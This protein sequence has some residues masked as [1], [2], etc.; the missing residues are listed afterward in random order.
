MNRSSSIAI[1]RGFAITLGKSVAPRSEKAGRPVCTG[2][3][4][5]CH[6]G[7]GADDK[8]I[9]RL[10]FQGAQRAR[11]TSYQ[12]ASILDRAVSISGCK[13]ELES[14]KPILNMSPGT[15]QEEAN[16]DLDAGT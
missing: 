13:L 15:T 6:G 7:A 12:L 2:Q 3:I 9:R 14:G 11:E 16:R 4:A 5:S 8:H 1:A 10:F